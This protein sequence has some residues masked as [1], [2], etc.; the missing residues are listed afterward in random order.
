MI[1]QIFYLRGPIVTMVR[2]N[3]PQ[4]YEKAVAWS[5]FRGTSRISMA[6]CA[7]LDDETEHVLLKYP[8]IRG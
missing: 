7:D 1:S 5:C 3:S 8:G 4:V 6:K 2:L